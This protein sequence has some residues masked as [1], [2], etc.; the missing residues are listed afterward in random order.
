L[1]VP[2]R[3]TSLP[4]VNSSIFRQ[5][6]TQNLRKKSVFHQDKLQQTSTNWSF[7][8]HNGSKIN[9]TLAILLKKIEN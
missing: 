6:Q 9:Y 1:V 8:E 7:P 2:N 3:A 4:I 5:K